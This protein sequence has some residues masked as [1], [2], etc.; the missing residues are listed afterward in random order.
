MT[1][2]VIRTT[3][4]ACAIAALG[5]SLSAHAQTGHMYCLDEGSYR[6][7]A[8]ADD[9][10]GVSPYANGCIRALSDGRAAVLLPSALENIN[11]VSMDQSLRRHAWGFL[12]QNGRLAIRPL[13]EDVRDFRHGLA[14]VQ[15]KGKWGFIDT[16]G[17]M[18]VPPRYDSVQDYAEIG[19]AVAT[20]DG[21]QQL[22]DRQGEPVGEP[23]DAGIQD[24]F[25]ADGVPA[26]AAVQYK[27]EFRGING[28]RRFAKPGVTI[29]QAYGQGLYIA[30]NDERRY[31][32]VDGDWNWVVEPT[33][34]DILTQRDGRPAVAF[35]RDGAVLIGA[36][37]KVS[38]LDQG[39]GSMQPVGRAFWSAELDR[40][41]GYAVLDATGTLVTTMKPDEAQA[42]QRFQ[43]T[44][45]YPSGETLMALVPGQPAPIKL[46]P[47]L[48]PARNEEGFVLF[49]D[50]TGTPAGLLTPKGVWL[51][52]DTAPAWLR[53]A[54][55]MEVRDGR[56]WVKKREGRLLNVV[57]ADG[58]VL[59]NPEA[60]E[61]A[62]Y[63]ELRAVPL[64][65]PGGPLAML[66]QSHCQCG[67]SGAGL[68]LAD[69]TL[70]SDPSWTD[71]IAL[72]DV[73][74]RESDPEPEAGDD[75]QKPD[76]LRFAA[77]TDRGLQLLD[78]Q[79]RPMSLPVQQHIGNFRHGYALVYADGVNRMIDRDGK[80][81]DLPDVFQTEIVAPGVVRY[82]KTAGADALWGLY[83][84]VTKKELAAPAFRKVGHFQNG[85]AVASLGA[86]R[87]GVIDQQGQWVLPASHYGIARVN[88]KL[89]R[90][91]QA[92][93]QGEDY[94]RPAAVFNAQGRALTSFQRLLQV[95][96]EEGGSITAAGENHRWIVAADG[97]GVQ[98]LQDATYS[99]IGD[100]LEIRR[101]VRYGYLDAQGAWQIGPMAAV[102]SVFQGSPA[103]ALAADDASTRLID[104]TGKTV[105]TL[106][107]GDWR[108]PQGSALLLRHYVANGKAMTD[109]V[110]LDGKARIK[111]EGTGS[112]YS[113]GR[114]VTQLSTSAV[115]AVDGKGALNGPAFDALGALHDGLAPARTEGNFG[116]VDG[117]GKFVI[118]T[119]YNAVTP[120]ADQRAV[121]STMELSKIIDPA[122]NAL[123]RVEMVCGMRTLYGSA[124]QRLWP[125]SLPAR[126][127]R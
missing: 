14:A 97:S 121:V 22:I 118:P 113:E 35:G 23:L 94:E 31:G 80:T 17:R 32:V 40:S 93:G 34:E 73:D 108:W 63:A 66:G 82:L 125:L 75:V 37:G 123:A 36:D 26:R 39:Y 101:A 92:G 28:E 99:R 107:A 116:Y 27:Q 62:Q 90:V 9:I 21:R 68:L 83:D 104:T 102:G 24:L 87:V 12:D 84:F 67:P 100:W 38:G 126:C 13:F 45:V 74:D 50:Q 81:Y 69:G 117:T 111:V 33:Y 20:L 1:S 30:I 19:L 65:M 18:A 59:L 2:R 48:S 89:W 64:N 96:A 7:D 86:D 72:D 127:R 71:L 114:A 55:S 78:A 8:Y 4:L 41:K 57:D 29:T 124:G 70:V 122:G 58:H 110:G 46:G 79:G 52:G 115:R 61:A 15:W 49:S 6:S 25:L 109:Y 60:V 120:F 77:E 42:S 103:R 10:S 43:D 98:D 85:Q 76:Q 53:E 54:G 95:S 56:L 106:P 11:R 51:N 88:D 16:R 112:A 5:A 91:M 105:A 44:I 119:D 3:R 47:A